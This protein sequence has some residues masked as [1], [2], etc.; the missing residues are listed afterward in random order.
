MQEK[1]KEYMRGRPFVIDKITQKSL[2]ARARILSAYIGFIFLLFAIPMSL[3]AGSYLIA[4]SGSFFS[5]S[6]IAAYLIFFVAI[7]GGISFFKERIWNKFIPRQLFYSKGDTHIIETSRFFF[8]LPSR[9]LKVDQ[10]VHILLH[11]RE[12]NERLHFYSVVL[13]FNNSSDDI[14]LYYDTKSRTAESLAKKLHILFNKDIVHEV[15][16]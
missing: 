15:Y 13:V 7:F 16:L 11:R 8:K 2:S 6:A 14:C 3:T 4:T 5:I 1:N 12:V 10:I 9:E